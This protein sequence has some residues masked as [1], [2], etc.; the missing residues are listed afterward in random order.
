MWGR[1]TGKPLKAGSM[2]GDLA[3]PRG[4]QMSSSY[5]GAGLFWGRRL[6]GWGGKGGGALLGGSPDWAGLLCWLKASITLGVLATG[7]GGVGARGSAERKKRDT[8]RGSASRHHSPRLP[9]RGSS[10]KGFL[11][12][13]HYFTGKTPTSTE[14]FQTAVL[15]ESPSRSQAKIKMIP[16][17]WR[18]FLS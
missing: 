3:G 17:A 1:C 2:D 8:R 16:R 10:N 9:T 13:F 15:A 14:D 11:F 7:G 4:T 18:C 12:S 5:P 6:G